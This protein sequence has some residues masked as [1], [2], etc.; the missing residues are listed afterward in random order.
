MNNIH[1]FWNNIIYALDN[2]PKE[3]LILNFIHFSGYDYSKLS[4]IHPMVG[5]QRLSKKK[6]VAR[7]FFKGPSA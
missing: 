1:Q 6:K 5:A 4:M 7:D 2:E 3:R